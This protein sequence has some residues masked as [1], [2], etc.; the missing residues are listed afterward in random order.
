MECLTR[1]CTVM[2]QKSLVIEQH[3]TTLSEAISPLGCSDNSS[4]CPMLIR[5]LTEAQLLTSSK[6]ICGT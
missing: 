1:N 4:R 6:K 2:G 3:L 5:Q